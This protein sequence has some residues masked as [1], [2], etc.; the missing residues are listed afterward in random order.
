MKEIEIVDDPDM[1]KIIVEDTR[2]KILR[3]LR[4]RD[5]TIS[6]M[7]SIL[8]KNVSTIFRH[9]K[10]LEEA[11]LV[12]VTGERK[13]RKVPE[14]LYGRTVRTIFLAP[15]SFERSAFTKRYREKKT[16]EIKH[17]LEDIG[18]RV[19][20]DNY[21]KDLVNYIDEISLSD[22]EKVKRD[23]DWNDL[24]SLKDILLLLNIP[25]RKIKEIRRKIY[26]PKT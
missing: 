4:F 14:K 11:G 21:L 1:I 25:D 3:L 20:D 17:A 12:K 7:A 10:K 6:E 18:Y 16:K 23:M 19:D 13:V 26:K 5:M 22:L 15:E 9:V 2:T 24:R 8:N